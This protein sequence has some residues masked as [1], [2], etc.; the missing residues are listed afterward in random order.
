MTNQPKFC[1][2]FLSNL[3]PNQAIWQHKAPWTCW[4]SSKM[5]YFLTFLTLAWAGFSDE[6]K[7]YFS[8]LKRKYIFAFK[9]HDMG[10]VTWHY[11]IHLC[12]CEWESQVE[13]GELYYT[14]LHYGIQ[15]Y[16]ISLWCAILYFTIQSTSVIT[17]HSK[18]IRKLGKP[19]TCGKKPINA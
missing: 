1:K 17:L 12:T 15:Y 18:N 10:W 14:I 3:T 7:Q 16:Y 9:L 11:L 13:R 6:T 5:K 8:K 19:W 2:L 4:M